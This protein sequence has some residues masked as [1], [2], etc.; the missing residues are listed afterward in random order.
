MLKMGA[1]AMM[2]VVMLASGAAAAL[3][4]DR[5]QADNFFDFTY[6]SRKGITQ[7]GSSMIVKRHDP[8]QFTVAVGEQKGTPLYGRVALELARRKPV[9][10]SG[11]L[12]FVVTD[13]AGVTAY[14]ADEPISMTLR[15]RAG[16][17]SE[18]FRFPFTVPDGHYNV[19]ATFSS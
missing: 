4:Q 9:R 18:R 13:D 19:T 14:T 6:R 16:Q 8:V 2:A 10:Y 12:T 15:P 3:I 7:A 5:D 17:R 1:L 11:T